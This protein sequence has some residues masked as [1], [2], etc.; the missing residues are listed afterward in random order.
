MWLG[1]LGSNGSHPSCALA[2]SAAA[3]GLVVL[4]TAPATHRSP[5]RSPTFASWLLGSR[6]ALPN[7]HCSGVGP[8]VASPQHSII[9]KKFSWIVP[10]PTVGWPPVQDT[11]MPWCPRSSVWL[12]VTTRFLKSLYMN[13]SGPVGLALF[14]SAFAL[15][16]GVL[17]LSR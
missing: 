3:G 16:M 5:V 4:G 12:T 1:S 15:G 6:P 2:P 9:C 17:V 13:D 7:S 14:R 11:V 8:V 10:P